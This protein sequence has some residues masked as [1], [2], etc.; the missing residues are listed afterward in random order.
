MTQQR[1][2]KAFGGKR[3]HA[4]RGYKPSYLELI[5]N[6]RNEG[7]RFI[8]FENIEKIMVID[9]NIT[10]INIISEGLVHLFRDLA[11]EYPAGVHIKVIIAQRGMKLK[12]YKNRVTEKVVMALRRRNLAGVDYALIIS[13]A[14]YDVRLNYL[15]II[16]NTWYAKDRKIA[17]HG[18]RVAKFTQEAR[19]IID[20]IYDTRWI[21]SVFEDVSR[22]DTRKDTEEAEIEFS[23]ICK[24]FEKENLPKGMKTA[25][26]LED[27]NNTMGIQ[28]YILRE[29][30]NA[31]LR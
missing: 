11:M 8:V 24:K 17:K 1:L 2:M 13:D 27:C 20:D 22:S 25:F 9:S 30:A 12:E 6:A 10:Y 29:I 28:D 31:Y 26:R 14:R 15:D 18:K 5:Q 23:N 7:C 19:A 16:C 4:C 21:Y 3:I